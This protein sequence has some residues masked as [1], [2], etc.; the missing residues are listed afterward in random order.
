MGAWAELGLGRALLPEFAVAEPLRSGALVRIPCEAPPLAL[1]L[2][3]RSDRES[4]PGL[5][6]LLYA[7]AA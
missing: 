2:V 3:W 6:G 7:A 1:R 4:L 5:R